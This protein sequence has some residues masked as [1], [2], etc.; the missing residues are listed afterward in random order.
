MSPSQV[1]LKKKKE[2]IIFLLRECKTMQKINFY[3]FVYGDAGP[4]EKLL[5]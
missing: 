3:F 2:K 5:S 1:H 4:Y